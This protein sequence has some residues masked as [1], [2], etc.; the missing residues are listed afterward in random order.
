MLTKGP[1]LRAEWPS[2]VK[3]SGRRS[4][5]ALLVGIL[6]LAGC[7]RGDEVVATPR[8]PTE[9]RHDM[10][11]LTSRFR[12]L[13]APVSADWVTWNSSGHDDR[14]PGPT[15]Y[16]LDATVRLDS[17]TWSRLKTQYGPTDH[18]RRPNVEQLL[19]SELPPGP[20]LTSEALDAAFTTPSLAASAYL[21]ADGDHLVLTSTGG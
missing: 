7:G 19:L 20:Y 5:Y 16:W 18:G 3:R 12:E 6:M 21:V 2:L 8:P 17:A 13:S 1:D 11:P 9:V 4:W 10:A 15:T 14:V